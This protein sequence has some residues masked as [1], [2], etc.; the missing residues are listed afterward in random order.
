M[1]IRQNE[2][3]RWIVLSERDVILRRLAAQNLASVVASLCEA[4]QGTAISE[5]PRR[6]GNRRRSLEEHGPRYRRVPAFQT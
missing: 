1:F 5:S 3:A 6:F 2:S 4:Q